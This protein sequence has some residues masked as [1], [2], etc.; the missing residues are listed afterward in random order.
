MAGTAVRERPMDAAAAVDAPT[1]PRRLGQPADGPA[2]EP[3]GP[4]VIIDVRSL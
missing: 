1:R 4:G 2:T 3:T